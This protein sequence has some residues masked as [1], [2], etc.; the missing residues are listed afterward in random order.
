V[1]IQAVRWLSLLSI[2]LIIGWIFVVRYAGRA[3]KEH[4]DEVPA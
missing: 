3:F 2:P 4:A 1:S